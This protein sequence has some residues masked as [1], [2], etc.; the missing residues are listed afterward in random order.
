MLTVSP[1]SFNADTEITIT[2]NTAVGNRELKSADK[3]YMHS[4]VVLTNINAP[5]GSDWQKVVG[6]WGQDNGV[7]VMTK[8]A[9]SQDLWQ[10]KLKPS[11]YYSL[12]NNEFPHWIGAVFRNAAGTVKATNTA[13]NYDF[14]FI[15]AASQDFFIRNQKSVNVIP[16]EIQ[17]IKIYPNPTSAK[18]TISG[19][20]QTHSLYIFNAEGK[21]VGKFEVADGEV[22][23][24]SYLPLGLYFYNIGSGKSSF[25]GKLVITE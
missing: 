5:K 17:N 18:I 2:L 8:V 24:V 10:I 20:E 12:S 25:S 19:I 13:G 14:G 15:D 4:G 1:S 16:T 6:S 7:G 11:T 21:E 23:D 9:G 3:I 22:L